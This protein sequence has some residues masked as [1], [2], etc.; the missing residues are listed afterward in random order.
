MGLVRVLN[1]DKI[2]EINRHNTNTFAVTFLGKRE[3]IEQAAFKTIARVAMTILYE[4]PGC[5]CMSPS[6]T[7]ID[8]CSL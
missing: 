4:L 1:G 5:V 6:E 3:K 2:N 7:L 8:W